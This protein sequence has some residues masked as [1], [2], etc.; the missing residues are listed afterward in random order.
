MKQ[1]LKNLI[2]KSMTRQD[3][4]VLSFSHGL[5]RALRNCCSSSLWPFVNS[6]WPCLSWKEKYWPSHTRARQARG[7]QEVTEISIHIISPSSQ[8]KDQERK[9]RGARTV[10]RGLDSRAVHKASTLGLLGP[11]AA[12]VN[13][14]WAQSSHVLLDLSSQ[15]GGQPCRIILLLNAC[16]LMQ[17]CPKPPWK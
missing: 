10:L 8:S 4:G 2:S 13:R 11:G 5:Q 3:L 15:V 6:P 14:T 17:G 16:G 12:Q 9:F 7:W 1:T